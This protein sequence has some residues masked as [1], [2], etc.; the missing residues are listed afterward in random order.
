MKED[1]I[2]EKIHDIKAKMD[3]IQWDIERN[4]VTAKKH[5][6]SKMQD[7]HSRLK[8]MLE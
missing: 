7:E 5:L 3:L 8:Q 6:Y 2:R 1:E 4:G